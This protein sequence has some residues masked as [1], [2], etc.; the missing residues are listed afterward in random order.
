[1]RAGALLV[2]LALAAS[3]ALALDALPGAKAVSFDGKRLA[4]AA[5][6]RTPVERWREFVP[7][8]EKLERWTALAS[9]R[10]YPG[11]RDPKALAGE[12]VKAL[13]QRYPGAPFAILENPSIGDVIV[14]FIAWP[15]DR[16][17][18]EFNLFRYGR[19][20]GGGVVAQQYA[21]RVYG[22]ASDFLRGLKAERPRLIDAM[23]KGGLKPAK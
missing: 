6:G 2:A 17:F 4:H 1:M 5:E 10:E 23:A 9:V 21:L 3:P 13:K 20:D 11:H 7:P 15:D 8:G 12:L 19:R 16:A 18:T 22:D 14:D